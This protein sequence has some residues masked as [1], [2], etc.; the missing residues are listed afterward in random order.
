MTA[1]PAIDP[2]TEAWTLLSQVMMSRK[3]HMLAT[4][5]AFELSPPQMWALRHLEPGTPLPMSALAELLHC[6]N[7]NVTGIVDRLESRGLVAREPGVRDRR[8]KFLRVT[9][10][11][12][13]VRDRLGALLDHPPE[14]L[15]ALTGAE[16]RQLTALL[17]KAAAAARDRSP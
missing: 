4:A 15:L 12:A 8:V 11:G 13:E 14:A 1:T 10:A 9:G 5:A 7:S 3:G 16:Q 2:A 6:D 17:R